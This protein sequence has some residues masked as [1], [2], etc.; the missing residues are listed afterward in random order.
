MSDE[1]E[2]A[3]LSQEASDAVDATLKVQG[4]R[5][6]VRL[7][8]MLEH[9]VAMKFLFRRVMQDIKSGDTRVVLRVMDHFLGKPVQR[10]ENFNTDH[11]TAIIES[12][13]GAMT[14]E[15]LVQYIRAK[16]NKEKNHV[17]APH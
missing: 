4:L 7:N 15:E 2:E 5:P 13:V 8:E 12:A 14:D 9:P 16:S 11:S 3:P 1:A 10:N 6:A 17:E